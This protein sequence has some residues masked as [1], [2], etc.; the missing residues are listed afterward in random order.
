M[1][2]FI[3]LPKSQSNNRVIHEY[4]STNRRFTLIIIIATQGR[5]HSHTATRIAS[6]RQQWKLGLL[7]PSLS[8]GRTP[9]PPSR[10]PRRTR[11]PSLQKIYQYTWYWPRI[12]HPMMHLLC[13]TRCKGGRVRKR[14]IFGCGFPMLVIN[15][16]KV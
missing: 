6:H 2:K 1:N 11:A 9:T 5:T 16:L 12:S 4:H 3:S 15:I 14:P 10:P 8:A 7:A 13:G